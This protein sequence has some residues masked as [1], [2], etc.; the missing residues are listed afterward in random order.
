MTSKPVFKTFGLTAHVKLATVFTTIS[1]R[2]TYA[3]D[4][5]T[6]SLKKVAF[7]TFSKDS[8]KNNVRDN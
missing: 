3:K 4:F 8:V 2:K 1:L 7:K 6:T 5:L